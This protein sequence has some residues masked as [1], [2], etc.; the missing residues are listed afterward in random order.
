MHGTRKIKVDLFS[1]STAGFR[2]VILHFKKSDNGQNPR[3]QDSVK[4][5]IELSET[6]S[7]K[8]VCNPSTEIVKS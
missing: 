1:E 3:K 4:R 8:L 6:S 7:I 2:N 5:P